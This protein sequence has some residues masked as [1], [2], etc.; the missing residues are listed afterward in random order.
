MPRR[1][2]QLR[3]ARL[4][5]STSLIVL[6]IVSLATNCQRTSHCSGRVLGPS[7]PL[8][9][10]GRAAEFRRSALCIKMMLRITF[11]SVAIIL[12]PITAWPCSC[13]P[14]PARP[15]AEEIEDYQLIV[16][17]TVESFEPISD[18]EIK[19]HFKVDQSYKGSTSN[20]IAVYTHPVEEMCGYPF[21][22]KHKYLLFA[23]K[24]KG[25]IHT[26]YCSR[27]Q[28]LSNAAKDIEFLKNWKKT[29]KQ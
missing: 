6:K 5:I 18:D 8:G 14:V 15:I 2:K 9:P 26:G 4:G 12:L 17:G 29:Q 11:F 19:V 25:K 28:L 1:I 21:K 13:V 27:T 24:N 16:S 3:K 22:K 20:K 23:Y 10:C 7:L